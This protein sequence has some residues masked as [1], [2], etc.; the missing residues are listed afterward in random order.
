MGETM[1]ETQMEVEEQR[2]SVEKKGKRE[3]QPEE[4]L[5]HR[6][7]APQCARHGRVRLSL[8]AGAGGKP[9]MGRIL[10]IFTAHG[11]T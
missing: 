6:S 3:D 1:E 4:G 9:A 2:N 5:Q 8:H 10:N 7:E 11:G